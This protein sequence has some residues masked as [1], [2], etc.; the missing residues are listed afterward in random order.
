MTQQRVSPIAVT[1][2]LPAT[3][4][5]KAQ[6]ASGQSADLLQLNNSSATTLVKVDSSGNFYAPSLQSTTAA[7]ATLTTNGDT[8]GFR[9][10]T[11]AAANK[12]LIVKA[13]ASQTGNLQEWQD[14]AATVLARINSS[15]GIQTAQVFT[16]YFS[17]NAN[18]GAYVDT[19]AVS[20]TW[21]LIQRTT[22]AVNLIIK[23]VASQTADLQQWQNSG[24]TILA[25]VTVAGAI[26]SAA[27]TAGIGYETGAGGTATQGAGSGKSTA[28]TLSKVTGQVTMNNAA[29]AANTTV[30]FVLTN[31][32]IAATDMV[33]VS[34]ISGGT[35]GSYT[36]TATPAAGS[37]TIYVRNVTAGSLS[38]AIVLQFVV[39]KAVTA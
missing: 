35:L 19:E 24:G 23:A 29:L 10:D 26:T 32:A 34:H 30:S 15:G 21:S 8:G 33:Y 1:S 9:I 25:R 18:S 28:V 37:A 13:A 7:K 36:C 6:A 4:L 11:G 2:L 5:L 20:G 16:R 39:I 12:G 27:A 38:E 14:S 3:V 22:T 17:N 31:T